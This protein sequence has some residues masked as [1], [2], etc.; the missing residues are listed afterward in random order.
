MRVH[1][2]VGMFIERL[3]ARDVGV[4]LGVTE[5]KLA[6]LHQVHD[7]ADD[8]TEDAAEGAASHGPGKARSRAADTLK[9]NAS[10]ARVLV[11]HIN[12]NFLKNII[13]LSYS[14]QIN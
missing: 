8:S 14:F 3:V 2:K 6:D 7:E 1:E 12:L 4:A 11:P 5:L 9:V 10:V 13:T